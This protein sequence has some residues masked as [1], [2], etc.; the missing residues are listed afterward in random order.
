MLGIARLRVAIEEHGAGRQLIRVRSWPH[1]PRAAL[2][3]GL[4]APAVAIV[5]VLNGADAVSIVL[6]ALAAGLLLRLA[7]ECATATAA[8][9]HALRRPLEPAP[10]E[11]EVDEVLP[12]GDPV[13]G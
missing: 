1:V 5:A 7:Y 9:A 4:L 12:L 3:I 8:I 6:G 10:S 13:P 11:P 2:L